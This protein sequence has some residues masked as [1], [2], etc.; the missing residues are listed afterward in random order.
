MQDLFDKLNSFQRR[1]VETD[2]KYVALRASV[3]SGKTTVIVY[4]VL[5]LHLVKKSL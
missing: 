5:Y 3:G 1:A 2:E 4:R